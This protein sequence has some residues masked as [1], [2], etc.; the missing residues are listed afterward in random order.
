MQTNESRQ[1]L[2][3]KKELNQEL[4]QHESALAKALDELSAAP[5]TMRSI[6]GDQ[7]SL[8]VLG[9]S[10]PQAKAALTCLVDAKKIQIEASK[11][12]I[13][14][15]RLKMAKLVIKKERLRRAC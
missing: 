13:S 2:A 12:R 11:K 10:E 5:I 1:I 9:M 6:L 3:K 4:Q 8:A 7:E 15:V 14:E